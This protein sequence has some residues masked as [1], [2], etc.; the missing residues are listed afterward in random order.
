MAKLY[1]DEV[2]D[3]EMRVFDMENAENLKDDEVEEVDV[4][5]GKR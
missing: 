2:L 5:K 3:D 4:K 1:D